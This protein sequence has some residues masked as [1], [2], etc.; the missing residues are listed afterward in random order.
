V[1]ADWLL[2]ALLSKILTKGSMP[3]VDRE[4]RVMVDLNRKRIE[5]EKIEREWNG[6]PD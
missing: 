3:T 2:S 4:Q 5:R 6:A 1:K